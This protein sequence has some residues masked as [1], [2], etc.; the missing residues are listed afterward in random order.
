MF[1]V[2]VK[3]MVTVMLMAMV[4]VWLWWWCSYNKVRNTNVP[5]HSVMLFR[6]KPGLQVQRKPSFKSVHF[7]FLQMLGPCMVHSSNGTK[8]RD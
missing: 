6:S 2:M 4:M 3:V 5:T 7:P 8:I 1:T